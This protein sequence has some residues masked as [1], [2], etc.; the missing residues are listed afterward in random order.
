MYAE[1]QAP[2]A[3]ECELKHVRLCRARVS[4]SLPD[5]KDTERMLQLFLQGSQ[6]RWDQLCI[7]GA[8][9]LSEHVWHCLSYRLSIRREH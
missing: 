5:S 6:G 2:A 8:C 9:P 1:L 3:V 4:I 7:L